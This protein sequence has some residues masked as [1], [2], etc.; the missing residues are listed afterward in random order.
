MIRAE[1]SGPSFIPVQSNPT[2]TDLKGLTIFFFGELLL[3][4][5]YEIIGSLFMGQENCF[6]YRRNFVTSGS[7]IAGC[8][9]SYKTAI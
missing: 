6:Y 8:D 9:C 2:T 5:W 1:T 4:P 3:L 7:G